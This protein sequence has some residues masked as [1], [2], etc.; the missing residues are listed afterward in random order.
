MKK[1]TKR[2]LMLAL[3][4]MMAVSTFVG[5]SISATAEGTTENVNTVTELAEVKLEA[6]K[7]LNMLDGNKQF[8]KNNVKSF[9]YFN[10][11]EVEQ[12]P[13]YFMKDMG[14]YL[15]LMTFDT[16]YDASAYAEGATL[17]VENA[18]LSLFV[19]FKT[20]D[21]LAQ[22]QT[23]GYFNIDI[24][25]GEPQADGTYA[26]SDSYKWSINI[27]S[28]FEKC[29]PGWNKVIV[30]L[31]L[32]GEKYGQMDWANIRFIRI[33]ATGV[34]G[35]ATRVGTGEYT[36]CTSEYEELTVIDEEKNVFPVLTKKQMVGSP[37]VFNIVEFERDGKMVQT[38]IKPRPSPWWTTLAYETPIDLSHYTTTEKVFDKN[39]A[40]L[41]VPASIEEYA[42]MQIYVYFPDE[43]NLEHYKLCTSMNLDVC[44][45]EPQ[46][47]G[48]YAYNDYYKYSFNFASL[49]EKCSVGW[50]R[51]ILP[52]CTANEK[53]ST[54]D[55]ANV[56]FVRINGMGDPGGIHPVTGK[57]FR[58]GFADIG[59]CF[60]TLTEMTVEGYVPP[61]VEEE[62]KNEKVYCNGGTGFHVLGFDTAF[63]D[64]QVISSNGYYKE[65]E[66]ALRLYGQ[67]T[68]STGKKLEKPVNL[69]MYDTLSLWMYVDNAENFLAMADGQI[70]LTSAGGR[71]DGN[72]YSWALKSLNIKDGWN[73][74]TLD[75]ASAKKGEPDI[76]K[77][78]Y[79]NIYFV[80]VPALGEV[81]I[82]DLH[83]HA[84]K[85]VVLESFDN[86][87]A[88][89]VLTEEGK[90]DKATNM[91][92]QGWIA[93]KKYATPVNIA[94]CDT[95]G[96]WIRCD[97]ETT[98]TSI[99]GTEIELSSSGQADVDELAFFL[100]DNLKVGWNYV[101][102]K[103]S[104]GRAGGT[105]DLTAINFVGVVKTGL[106]MVTC[107]F[108]DLRA[109]EDKLENPVVIDPIEKQVVISADKVASG[110][111][112]GMTIDDV[113]YKEGFASL[114]TVT[115]AGTTKLKAL[116]NP[117]QSGL[118]LK[119]EHEL[120]YAFWFYVEDVSKLTGLYVELGSFDG[121]PFE[122]EWHIDLSTIQSGWNWI[123]FKASEAARPSGVIDTNNLIRTRIVI[124]G[125]A[126]TVKFDCFVVVDSTVDG[127]FDP[128]E[129]KIEL[130]PINS[131]VVDNCET[132]WGYMTHVTETNEA[133]KK[134][135][136]SSV[137]VES[138]IDLATKVVNVGKTELLYNPY[139]SNNELGIAFWAYFEDASK[140]TSAKI[141]LLNDIAG[142][143][144]VSWTIT[145]NLTDGWNYIVLGVE[146]A[147]FFGAFDVDAINYVQYG[148]FAT[149]KVISLVDRIRVI[150][151]AIEENRA[152]PAY[153]GIDRHPVEDKVIIDCNSTGGFIFTGNRVDKDDFRY[154]TGS[155]Y[156][157][158][159]GY[160]L[161]A[162][163]LDIG[164]TDLIKKTFVMGLWV[165]I[166]DITL[167]D[168][169]SFSSQIEIGSTNNFD[170]YELYWENWYEGLSNGWNWVVL[171]GKDAHISG[172]APDFDKLC[173]FRIYINGVDNS[174][175][176]IDRIT[177]SN[178]YDEG[179]FTAPDWENEV[180]N[181]DSAFSGANGYIAE[182][183]PYLDIRHEDV[184]E[185]F[186]AEGPV[187]NDGCFAGMSVQIPV[188]MAFVFI[189]AGMLIK[190]RK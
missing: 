132:E 11:T 31:A 151:Y 13:C 115:K 166:E 61:V 80:G 99:A 90:V 60:T 66:G 155:V 189:A 180:I 137:E 158:G 172:S 40:S 149:E 67:G 25:S 87:F 153:E 134:E 118:S 97:D 20:E 41:N 169:D 64:G 95:I 1:F 52:L 34:G 10:G 133:N 177:I 127:A 43:E 100:P 187:V 103:I 124:D 50:N 83:A 58:I 98:C 152:E 9:D 42:A 112:N 125:E 143:N 73:W 159:F 32:A 123:T 146:A 142:V 54:M 53:N 175:L 56:R 77:I 94:D 72:E 179:I 107:F 111:F 35:V 145:E 29:R 130:N 3:S 17:K 147:E 129:D 106:P 131:V 7:L 160:Q 104:E 76:K 102:W 156:T 163:G 135:G 12:K 89:Q 122:L 15:A 22:Y 114:S 119:G 14:G 28:A 164:A 92:G 16:P 181:K 171:E 117:V 57:G 19:F 185:G 79:F 91:S 140:I 186:V 96:M 26:Y 44:S 6:S 51:L 46:A 27:V 8:K 74:I 108:D 24:C 183:A 174:T 69:S 82:D 109:Y 85:G 5:I 176:K 148:V 70:E 184:A 165:W 150:N 190:K 167:Y 139:R 154:G 138:N 86:G 59:A 126:T 30:P 188:C 33:N 39:I 173:R 81:I 55:W 93:R 23:A 113:E 144:G 68:G 75:L 121:Q 110:V 63:G 168:V 88:G 162:L 101:T 36:I 161:Y 170:E 37:D 178:I 105:I 84:S 2:F 18:A 45:G 71:D 21:C 182:N 157:S 62:I 65:G 128:I 4:V 49:F 47:D 78:D 116:F 120:G 141:V 38:Y 48:T 136:Y